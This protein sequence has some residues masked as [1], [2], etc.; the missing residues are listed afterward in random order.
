LVREVACLR[1]R[2]GGGTIG[3]RDGASKGWGAG[4]WR[5]AAGR[6]TVPGPAHRPIRE[7][8]PETQSCCVW[9]PSC[10]TS[11]GTCPCRTPPCQAV[12]KWECA[13]GWPIAAFAGHWMARGNG[14][15]MAGVFPGEDS[16]FLERR[17]TSLKKPSGLWSAALRF[18]GCHSRFF[19]PDSGLGG[20]GVGLA[21]APWSGCCG[22]DCGWPGGGARPGPF[23]NGSLRVR[24][25]CRGMAQERRF[26]PA[27]RVVLGGRAV[28][29]RSVAAAK[30]ALWKTPAPAAGPM[31]PRA[32]SARK[33]SGPAITRTGAGPRAPTPRWS[34][35]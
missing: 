5:R 24:S 9:T 16:R 2:R 32:Q 15:C 27:P 33:G 29:G 12:Q 4:R 35:R 23:G 8:K 17:R 22:R 7:S 11:A 20:A 6:R 10:A 26:L 25:G 1:G 28:A 21:L 31:R 13:G 34:V 14:L 19:L 30:A 18:G 3:V